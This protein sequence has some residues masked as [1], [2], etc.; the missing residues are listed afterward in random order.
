[1]KDL[2]NSTQQPAAHSLADSLAEH[3]AGPAA[4][5]SAWL[6][7]GDLEHA[8][9]LRLAAARLACCADKARSRVKAA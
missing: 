7:Y 3:A 6:D 2:D 5:A 8:A 1:L 4:I 9:D